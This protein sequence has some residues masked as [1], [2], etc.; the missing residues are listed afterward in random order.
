MRTY[1]RSVHRTK[2]L[3]EVEIHGLAEDLIG[4]TV[5]GDGLI[6]FKIGRAADDDGH[7]V[8]I[9]WEC[10][11]QGKTLESESFGWLEDKDPLIIEVRR[12]PD[13]PVS[14]AADQWFEIHMGHRPDADG[15]YDD[16]MGDGEGPIHFQD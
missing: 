14:G 15:L 7:A 5:E 3:I 16:K 4:M 11:C 10:N 8:T 1:Q 12:G 2:D 9:H 6:P 13:D